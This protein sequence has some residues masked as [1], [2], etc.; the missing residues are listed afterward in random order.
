MR[1]TV[2]PSCGFTIQTTLFMMSE[3][4]RKR[5]SL[6]YGARLPVD[7]SPRVSVSVSET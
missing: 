4:K 3:T 6:L 1:P 5:E 2:A 7:P